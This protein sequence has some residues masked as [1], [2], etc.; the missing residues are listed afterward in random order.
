VAQAGSQL[1][2]DAKIKRG[3]LFGLKFM[4]NAIE[5]RRKDAEQLLDEFETTKGADEAD[6]SSDL[7]YHDAEAEGRRPGRLVFRPGLVKE[8][9][10]H[11]AGMEASRRDEVGSDDER[12]EERA[13]ELAADRLQTAEQSAREAKMSEK[14]ASSAVR[15]YAESIHAIGKVSNH[16]SDHQLA[17]ENAGFVD[18]PVSGSASTDGVKG[19]SVEVKAAHVKKQGGSRPTSAPEA[20]KG[21]PWLQPI[22]PIPPSARKNPRSEQDDTMLAIVEPGVRVAAPNVTSVILSSTAAS[23]KRAK[24]AA[25]EKNAMLVKEAFAGEGARDEQDFLREK[26]AIAEAELPASIAKQIAPL[27]DG[28]ALLPGWG[29]W[30]GEGARESTSRIAARQA[31]EDKLRAIRSAALAKRKDSDRGLRHVIINERRNKA[32]VALTVPTLPYPFQSEEQYA[33]SIGMPLG[34]EWLSSETHRKAVRPELRV[35]PGIPLHPMRS[36]ARGTAKPSSM[37]ER[38]PFLA[39]SKKSH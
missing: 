26:E 8:G 36:I 32:A 27:K 25:S 10:E 13:L 15:A 30:G 35:V 1:Q 3:G 19:T 12:N 39:S 21:N 7:L 11:R 28:T 33:A 6:K 16:S 14:V 20:D 31:A 23:K 17:Q 9:E 37:P 4:Q 24:L 5:K 34:R 29:S 2:A 38:K 22:A 18:E